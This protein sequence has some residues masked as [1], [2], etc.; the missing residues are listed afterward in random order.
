MS[1]KLQIGLSGSIA[2]LLVALGGHAFAADEQPVPAKWKVQE[3]R[4]SYAGFTTA[5]DCDA[6]AAKIRTILL[7]LGA[8][9]STQ[10]RATGCPTNWPSRTFFVTITAATPVPVAELEKQEAE[11]SS[12]EKSR[13]EL[14]KRL[15]VKNRFE[16]EQFLASWKTVDLE[17]ERRLR[18]E[19][20]DCELMEDL[21]DEVF[22]KLGIKIEEE[23]I[24]CTPNQLSLQ[25]PHIRVSAL[26]Q[27]QTADAQ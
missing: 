1:R 23:R 19:A 17:K 24:S 25:P 6:V 4:F 13:E 20:G 3:V 15:G 7:T 16:D 11:K 22:P 18:I 9:E 21:R 2:A 8:H 26:A 14:L 10:V 12:A 5:Y 27:I